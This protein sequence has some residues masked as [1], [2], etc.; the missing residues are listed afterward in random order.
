MGT[1]EREYSHSINSNK[2]V[3][4]LQNEEMYNIAR[5]TA[6]YREQNIPSKEI[7][8]F[9]GRFIAINIVPFSALETTQAKFYA[10]CMSWMEDIRSNHSMQKAR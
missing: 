10:Q 7:L 4:T 2:Y 9:I 3:L 1:R 6:S 5:F 8:D